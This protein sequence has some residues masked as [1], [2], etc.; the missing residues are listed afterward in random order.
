MAQDIQ[1]GKEVEQ[2]ETPE[3]NKI[4]AEELQVLIEP[5]VEWLN[6]IGHP[7]MSVTITTFGVEVNQ[8]I[9]GLVIPQEEECTGQ[10]AE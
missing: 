1:T 10:E 7:H 3:Q 5:V 4:S 8:G 6:A 9:M 2:K